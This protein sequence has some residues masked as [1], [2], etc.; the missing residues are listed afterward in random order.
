MKNE[1]LKVENVGDIILSRRQ[2][3]KGA[4]KAGFALTAGFLYGDLV[5]E[6]SLNAEAADFGDFAKANF[7][8]TN[9][10]S[11]DQIY[12]TFV[13]DFATGEFISDRNPYIKIEMGNVQQFTVRDT[14]NNK[15]FILDYYKDCIKNKKHADLSTY[16]PDTN[17]AEF[18]KKCED[19]LYYLSLNPND[20]AVATEF[21]NY[22]KDKMLITTKT[23]EGDYAAFDPYYVQYV[24]VYE[25]VCEMVQAAWENIPAISYLRQNTKPE[26]M[27]DTESYWCAQ[28]IID[29][30]CGRSDK[31][32]IDS[33]H[34]RHS[35]I[36]KGNKQL[37]LLIRL[38]KKYPS[39]GM[40]YM[41]MESLV[42]LRSKENMCSLLDMTSAEY[43]EMAKKIRKSRENGLLDEEN[44][45]SVTIT[46][47]FGVMTVPYASTIADV[48]KSFH[49]DIV[50]Q[51][52]G[53]K[54]N[55]EVV[56]FDTILTDNNNIEFITNSRLSENTEENL[57]KFYNA[58]DMIEAER[59][60]EVTYHNKNNGRTLSL[61]KTA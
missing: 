8:E 25:T 61:V 30:L 44:G 5:S 51:I 16:Y 21:L 15:P 12:Q 3:M 33:A 50:K 10:L 2:V 47:K 22:V 38:N 37:W 52:T 46:T 19:Y 9:G 58:I 49:V 45:H 27:G 18:L 11:Y 36:T 55:N 43:D 59:M 53:V 29:Y 24:P 13:N 56:S 20:T 48:M 6:I 57:I 28:V 14:I 1:K 26:N 54:I 35:G 42:D 23:P 17:Q 32:Y 40:K 41:V 39:Y 34:L 60:D 7:D 4:V 31:S